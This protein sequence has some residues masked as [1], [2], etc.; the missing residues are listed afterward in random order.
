MS[1]YSL[2]PNPSSPLP[3]GIDRTEENQKSSASG[4]SIIA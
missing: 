1:L 3:I 4:L 2:I